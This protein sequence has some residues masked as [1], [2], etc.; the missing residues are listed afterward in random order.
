[1]TIMPA[2][3]L[4]KIGFGTW[5]LKPAD[6]T[7]AVL[8]A[9]E[10]GYRFIDTAQAYGNEKA[11]G[12]AI[13]KCGLARDDLII[14]TKINVFNY[15]PEKVLK[16]AAISLQK[17]GLKSVDLLYVHYP[18]K[19]FGYKASTTLKAF[20]QLVDEGKVGHIGV[21]NFNIPLL[22]EAIS[23]CDGF[24]KKILALQVEHHPLL[25]QRELRDYT[26]SHDM[27]FIAYS[28]LVRGK[29]GSIPEI[30]EVAKKHGVS[31]SQ[32]SLAWEMG[33]G[34]IPIPKATSEAHIKDNFASQDLVLDDEDVAKID[35]I[36]VQKRLQN[37]PVVK[38]KW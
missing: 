11:V 25:Q 26:A 30:A 37:P 38:P 4:P 20:S 10:V 24:G 17:L 23:V 19:A 18:A 31:D 35:G 6:C 28:P 12:E 22:D 27:Y 8:K 32:V 5:K 13:A 36:T 15:K 9:I 1:M 21:S 16:T 2:I 29:A 7:Q 33:H 3:Q 34:T 14:A